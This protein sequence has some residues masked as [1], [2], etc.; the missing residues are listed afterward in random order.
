MSSGRAVAS[1]VA[2]EG[3]GRPVVHRSTEGVPESAVPHWSH[4]GDGDD[5][6]RQA[7]AQSETGPDRRLSVTRR[8]VR[9]LL[10]RLQ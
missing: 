8:A 9:P 4:H 3:P 10:G 1:G 6:D 5:A 7:A 2:L